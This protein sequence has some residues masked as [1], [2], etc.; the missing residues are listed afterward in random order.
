MPDTFTRP[1]CQNDN[2]RKTPDSPTKTQLDRCKKNI[3]FRFGSPP[4]SLLCATMLPCQN[5]SHLSHTLER[6]I[7]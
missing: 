1:S 4:K 7:P 5:G 6:Q 2:S 3:P